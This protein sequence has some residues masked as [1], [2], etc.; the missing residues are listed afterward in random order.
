LLRAC[1]Q[2]GGR[3]RPASLGRRQKA[4]SGRHACAQPASGSGTSSPLTAGPLTASSSGSGSA[5]A[6]QLKPMRAALA[7]RR[8]AACT[9]ASPVAA[10]STTVPW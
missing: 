1:R 8:A 2:P 10:V 4:G 7:A 3:E 5:I 9:Y 6:E